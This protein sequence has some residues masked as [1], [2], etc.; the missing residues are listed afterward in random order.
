MHRTFPTPTPVS[1]R[2]EIWQGE[3]IV[4]GRDTDTTTVELEPLHGDSGAQDLIEAARVEQRGDEILV[5]LP[6][7]K[8]SFFR[9]RADVQATIT[10][11]AFSAAR[12]E[13][14]S[15]DVSTSGELGETRISTGSGDVRVEH[16]VT[17][18][19]RTGS[20][21]ID[22]GVVEGYCDVKGGSA[23]IAVGRVDGD[24][25]V[26]SG[27]GDLDLGRVAGQLKVKTGSGDVVVREGGE[28][29]DAMAG[30]GDVQVRRVDHGRV[31]AKTGSGD[32]SVGVAQGTAVFLDLNTVTGDVNCALDAAEAPGDDTPVVELVV[33]SA[34][35]D[36]AVEYA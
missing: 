25:T 18:M 22:L 4:Q 5:L 35:G 20:G 29:I 15:A 11:P 10:L 33:S 36:V 7:T 27:S 9:G 16:A 26:L 6:K 19:V 17:A 13:T 32:V 21:D 34:T 1:L 24:C 31:E 2:V 3:V 12:I 28:G 8:T 14:A 23:D 30:S